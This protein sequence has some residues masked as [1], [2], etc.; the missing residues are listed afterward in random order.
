MRRTEPASPSSPPRFI[1]VNNQVVAL[2]P[3]AADIARAMNERLAG[4]LARKNGAQ[5]VADAMNAYVD[6]VLGGPPPLDIK[7]RR[8]RRTL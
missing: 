7:R 5:T 8:R 2:D 3:E 4:A 6:I 1:A